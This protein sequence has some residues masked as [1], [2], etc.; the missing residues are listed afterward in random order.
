MKGKVTAYSIS[1]NAGI[2]KGDDGNDYQFNQRQWRDH[3]LPM[4]NQSVTFDNNSNQAQEV[5]GK[6]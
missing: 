5:S 6:N 2:I 1:V 3:K 4:N